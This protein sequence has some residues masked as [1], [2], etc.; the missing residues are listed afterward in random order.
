MT[1][2]GPLSPP[3]LWLKE[4]LCK[5]LDLPLKTNTGCSSIFRLALLGSLFVQNAKSIKLV[6]GN[7]VIYV[8]LKFSLVG[9]CA[10]PPLQS[11]VVGAIFSVNCGIVELF[12]TL[13]P[14]KCPQPT[15]MDRDAF[16]LSRLQREGVGKR[17]V[18]FAFYQI[19]PQHPPGLW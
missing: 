2:L 16:L 18:R 3:P 17:V 9:A 7:C 1:N 5:P 10:S 11:Y 12:V 19:L 13:P 8:W 15:S 14:P 4:V 6:A